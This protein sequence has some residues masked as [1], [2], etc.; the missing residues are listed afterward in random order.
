MSVADLDSNQ[1]R[2]VAQNPADAASS[3]GQAQESRLSA[4]IDCSLE[5]QSL[6]SSRSEFL[7][8]KGQ[9]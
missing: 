5:A 7:P 3:N 6:L 2:V 1:E 8:D 9:E 4:P